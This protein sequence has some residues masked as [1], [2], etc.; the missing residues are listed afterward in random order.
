[1]SVTHAA[2]IAGVSFVVTL[3]VLFALAHL[4]HVQ[5]SAREPVDSHG[6]QRFLLSV[7]GPFVVTI[8]FLLIVLD[9]SAPTDERRTALAAAAGCFACWLVGVTRWSRARRQ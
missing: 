5:Q 9:A 2:I 6:H 1:M 3:A 8:A 4:R 7:V